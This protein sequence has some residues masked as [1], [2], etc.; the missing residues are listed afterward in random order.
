MLTTVIQIMSERHTGPFVSQKSGSRAIH[1]TAERCSS[2]KREFDFRRG[3][4]LSNDSERLHLDE[5]KGMMSPKAQTD[6][7]AMGLLPSPES[8]E[9][10]RSS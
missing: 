8:L 9:I 3:L 5:I 7:P 4:M 1:E 10:E 6:A 2:Q